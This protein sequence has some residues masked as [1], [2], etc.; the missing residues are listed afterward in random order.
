LEEWKARAEAELVEALERASTSEA[1][2]RTAVT[3]RARIERE[4][5]GRVQAAEARAA[6]AAGRLAAT[7]RAR[8]EI[9][10]RVLT[11]REELV[12]K[13]RAGLERRD[14]A[15]AQEV[16]R[17]QQSVQERAR[18]LKVAELE[19]ARL[20]AR[21]A[22][23]PATPSGPNQVV[24]RAAPAPPPRPAPPTDGDDAWQKLVDDLDKP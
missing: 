6:D 16:A 3:E 8:K 18:A 15:K 24:Q 9:E 21:A 2:A 7:E 23:G 10:A 1:E 4:L 17:L 5:G 11:E 13:Q 20:K 12:G 19:L 14:A 22:P